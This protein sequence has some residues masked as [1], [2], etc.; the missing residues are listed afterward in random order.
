MGIIFITGAPGSGKST[1]AAKLHEKLGCPWYEFGWT[2]EFRQK[3]PHTTLTWEEEE[4]LSM[5]NLLL[6]ADNYLRRGFDHV[7]LTDIREPYTDTVY[8]HFAPDSIRLIT[9]IAEDDEVLRHR[10]LTRDNGN[11]YRN[12]DEAVEL[13]RRFKDRP[14]LPKE[15]RIRCD[16]KAPEE[17]A[18]EILK[19][20]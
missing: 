7:I 19:S 14:I 2:P 1:V 8:S 6:V 5:E 10:V 13:N 9:L 15:S 4:A 11:E 3:N 20:I 18:A 16:H 17:I 12:A